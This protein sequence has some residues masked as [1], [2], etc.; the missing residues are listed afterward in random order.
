MVIQGVKY[1]SDFEGKKAIC[2]AAAQLSQNGYVVGGDGSLS[3]RTGPNAIW[4]TAADAN[5]AALNQMHL[6]R[7]DMN[8]KPGYSN[9]QAALPEDL[10]MHLRIYADDSSARCVIHAYPP[11]FTA[12]L[13]CGI[14][15][16]PASYTPSVRRL[17]EIGTV[18]SC[19]ACSITPHTGGCIVQGD[20]CVFWGADV[21]EARQRFDALEY[22]AKV[23]FR[24]GTSAAPPAQPART[25][26]PERP[27]GLKGVTAIVRPSDAP[28]EQAREVSRLVSDDSHA[29]REQDVRQ[30]AINTIVQRSIA[31]MNG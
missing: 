14:Q 26:C 15:Y 10:E 17:G 27:A 25:A 11:E 18:S 2:T 9:T 30:A 21:Q 12:L 13:L 4:I 28:M 7:V 22:Y 1:P 6:I 3:V 31:R 24:C 20:G 5:K 16:T 29:A 8:G 23:R 19:K